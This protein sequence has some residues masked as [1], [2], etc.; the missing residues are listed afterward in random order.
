MQEPTSVI[1]QN[2]THAYR[3]HT[4]GELREADVGQEVILK[5]W[6][7]TRRDLGGVIFIDLRDRFGL[8]QV[9]FSPQYDIQA[10]SVAERLRGEYVI[11]VK[12][13]VHP[14]SAE[15]VN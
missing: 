11:S 8:T 13:T 9:V 3:T 6:V 2:P 15:T 7:D 1:V 10:H 4:C 5:G 12:G 14:R